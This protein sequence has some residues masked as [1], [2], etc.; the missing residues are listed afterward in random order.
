[1]IYDASV[2]AVILFIAFVIAVLGISKYFASKTKSS[3]GYYAAGGDTYDIDI[4]AG[5]NWAVANGADV[6][7]MAFSGPNESAAL[8]GAIADAIFGDLNPGGRTTVM[9]KASP[10]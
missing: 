2:F 6:I 5:I 3:S 4:I 1:M 7:L 10:P 9:A 8:A